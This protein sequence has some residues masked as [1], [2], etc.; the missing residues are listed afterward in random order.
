MSLKTRC[1]TRLSH[2]ALS[3]NF[4]EC[5]TVLSQAVLLQ[6]TDQYWQET[7]CYN[8]RAQITHQV[9]YDAGGIACGTSIAEPFA[10]GKALNH[11]RRTV[12]TTIPVAE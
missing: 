10:C 12:H 11:R 4:A 1:V 5:R 9:C 7:Q 6:H 2:I 3:T 8:G